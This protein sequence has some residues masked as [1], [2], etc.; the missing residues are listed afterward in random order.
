M[1]DGAPVVTDGPFL[2]A[3]EHL[4]GYYE[5]DCESIERAVEL[6]AMMPEARYQGVEVRPV[7]GPA[8]DEM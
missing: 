3:K 5:V 6:A 2:E 7:M 1:R 4:A 8:G